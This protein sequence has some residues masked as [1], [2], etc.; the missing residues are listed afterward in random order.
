MASEYQIKLKAALDDSSIKKSIQKIND[1]Q[2]INFKVSGDKEVMTVTNRLKDNMGQIT[3]ETEK[4]RKTADGTFE[5]FAKS[6]RTVSGDTST[7]ADTLKNATGNVT[8]FIGAFGAFTSVTEIIKEMASVVKNMDDA[9]T[10]YKKVSDLTGQ[11]LDSF[12]QKA[13]AVGESVA[14]TGTEMVEASTEF[15]K[16]GY[17]DEESLELAKIASLYQNVAD[18]QMSA[19]QASNFIIAQM[20]AFNIEAQ[21]SI[22]IVDAI[23]EVSNNYAVSSADL[24]NNLGNVSSTMAAGKTSYEETLG[25]MTAITEIT[26]D[27]NSASV[28]LKV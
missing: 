13:T 9:L 11:S 22:H 26:R 19:G 25:L 23:N 3:T 27:A 20:K 14:R 24:A 2:T 8:S 12:V 18:E 5:S 21:D 28:G 16:S 7:L 10:E 17:S 15:K 1:K 6:T 4:F